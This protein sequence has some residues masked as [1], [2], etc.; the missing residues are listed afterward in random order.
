MTL[1]RQ[2]NYTAKRGQHR[3]RGHKTILYTVSMNC[4]RRSHSHSRLTGSNVLFWPAVG[5]LC[6]RAPALHCCI[7]CR[8]PLSRSTY[9]VRSLLCPLSPPSRH[10]P[11][12]RCRPGRG[13]CLTSTVLILIVHIQLHHVNVFMCLCQPN[14]AL[15]QLHIVCWTAEAVASNDEV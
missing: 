2:C 7:V 13:N 15:L 8:A 11:P 5:L 9:F 10:P 3:G 4:V 1:Q 14:R 12:P 6:P